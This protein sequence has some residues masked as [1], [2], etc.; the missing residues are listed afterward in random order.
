MADRTLVVFHAAS[1]TLLLY[2]AI[3]QMHGYSVLSYGQEVSTF[4]AVE[5]VH[6]QLLILDDSSPSTPHP[7]TLLEA[8][9]AR[10]GL[11]TTP[12]VI[13]TTS[14][15]TAFAIGTLVRQRVVVINKPFGYTTLL[16][17]IDVVLSTPLTKLSSGSAL[18]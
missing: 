6:P 10:P 8:L 11:T 16:K 17:S 4:D 7:L 13:S 18:R 12:V 9:R 14:P 3:L 1:T 5:I 15:T 2:R